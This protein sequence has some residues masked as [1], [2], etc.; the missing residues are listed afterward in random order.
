M[1]FTNHVL[2]HI[3]EAVSQKYLFKKNHNAE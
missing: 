3:N 2:T 1:K